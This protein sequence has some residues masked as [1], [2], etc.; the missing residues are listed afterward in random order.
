MSAEAAERVLRVY[1][2]QPRRAAGAW[3]PLVCGMVP[4]SR[5]SRGL[6]LT[7]LKRGC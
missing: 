6:A 1:G 2:R 7:G 4:V 3:R 5:R